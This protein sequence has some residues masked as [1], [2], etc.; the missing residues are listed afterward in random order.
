M[1]E[2][3]VRALKDTDQRRDALK[4]YADERRNEIDHLHLP[5][6]EHKAE[7]EDLEYTLT[8]IREKFL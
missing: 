4:K 8:I 1:L 3:M 7:L 5:D 6:E 2:E